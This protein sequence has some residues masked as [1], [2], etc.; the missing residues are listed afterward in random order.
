MLRT[1]TWLVTQTYEGFISTNQ[2]YQLSFVTSMEF[3]S[4]HEN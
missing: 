3:A 4:K 2:L 1:V